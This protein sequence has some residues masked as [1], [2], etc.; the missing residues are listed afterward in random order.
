MGLALT[1]FAQLW[2][3]GIDVLMRKLSLGGFVQICWWCGWSVEWWWVGFCQFVGGCLGLLGCEIW[4]LKFHFTRFE[5]NFLGFKFAGFAFLFKYI[6]CSCLIYQFYLGLSRMLAW[7]LIL[8]FGFKV[9]IFWVLNFVFMFNFLFMFN[10]MWIYS[11]I[12]CSYFLV[13]WFS[14]FNFVFLDLGLCSCYSC[15]RHT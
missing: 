1:W 15:L 3:P 6:M 14:D 5:F 8:G 12:L 2:S 13:F 7:I 11:L 9:L 10:L 4:R